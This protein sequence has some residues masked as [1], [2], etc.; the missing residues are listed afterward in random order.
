MGLHYATILPLASL[1][2]AFIA[3][4]AFPVDRRLHEKLARLSWAL[5]V[6]GWPIYVL[7]FINLDYRLAEVAGNA[8]ED[9]SLALRLGASWSGS[10]SSLYLF[11][12]ALATASLAI[13]RTLGAAFTL[14][15][16]AVFIASMVAATLNGA[17]AVTEARGGLGLNPLLK[18]Y[19]VVPHPLTTFTGYALALVASL[20]VAAGAPARL[21]RPL[22]VAS[23]AFVSAG[24]AL[25]AYWSYE[26]FGWG[27]YWAWDPVEVSELMVWLG[28]TA[29]LHSTGSLEPFTRPLAALTVSSVMLALYVTRSGLSPLH[30]F[31][32]PGLGNVVLLSGSI[33][34]LASALALSYALMARRE[35]IGLRKVL[36]SPGSTALAVAALTL[37]ASFIFTY[38]TLLAPAALTVL[39]RGAT[40]PT[41]EAGARFYAP[42]LIAAAITASMAMVINLAG[43][44]WRATIAYR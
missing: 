15:S 43:L 12:A 4:L 17:F 10:G 23:W 28:V 33:A 29:L 22:A 8:S 16:L 21:W 6:A 5:A 14:P 3:L 19:W 30:S 39:G 1:A 38:S 31:A 44:T 42:P 20:A 24:I 36:E 25:G 9:L 32:G 2:T 41:M 7:A 40:I 18:S 34:A 11:S 35:F 13:A 27:G 26:T 37:S